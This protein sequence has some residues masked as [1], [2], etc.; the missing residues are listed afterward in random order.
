MLRRMSEL[1]E[2]LAPLLGGIADRD[3]S[4][5]DGFPAESISQLVRAGLFTAPLPPH[6]GG[7]GV[8]IVELA[9]AIEMLS[10]AA[11]SVGLLVAMPVGL[12]G[13]LVAAAPVVPAEQRDVWSQCVKFMAAELAAGRLFGACNS[14]RGAGGSLDATRTVARR[15]TD[16]AI[17]LDGD[18]ILA[19]FGRH[20]DWLFSIARTDADARA[21][22]GAGPVEFFLVR[23]SESGV[24]VHADWDGFGMRSTESQ[25]V[26]YRAAPAQGPF[27]F[28][29]Y[30]ASVQPASY[31]SLL[32]AAIPLGCAAGALELLEKTRPRSPAL[33]LRLVESR[34]R[35]EALAAYLFATAGAW[36]P[37]APPAAQLR[38]LRCKTHVSAEA[39]KL[40]GELFALAGGR[41]YRR[42]DR[43]ARLL[44]DSYAGV[45]LRL[46]YQLALDTL[47]ADEAWEA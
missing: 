43:L 33:R 42:G 39:C 4:D 21:F 37:G 14:E 9:R 23:C 15:H 22:P 44:A 17:T 11:P 8:E 26:T 38:T 13:G 45:S 34:M 24:T 28:P 10:A 25:S 7:L 5:P 1:F 35:Y 20:A 27:G 41:H 29:G 18:K 31:F 2:R 30:M 6:R 19:S 36:R 12:I 40:M 3:A 32:F 47:V 16:G 46:P